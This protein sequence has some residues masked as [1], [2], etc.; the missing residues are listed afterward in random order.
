MAAKGSFSGQGRTVVKLT[1]RFVDFLVHV[2]SHTGRQRLYVAVAI[3]SQREILFSVCAP[4]VGTFY[5]SGK[6]KVDTQPDSQ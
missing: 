3:V 4:C 2:K 1:K 5:D 6:I